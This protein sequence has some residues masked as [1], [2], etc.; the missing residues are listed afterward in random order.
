MVKVESKSLDGLRG[1]AALHVALGH[2]LLYSVGTDLMGECAIVIFFLISGFVMVVG[3]GQKKYS[4]SGGVY[5]EIVCVNLDRLNICGKK[6][7]AG[8]IHSEQDTEKAEALTQGVSFPGYSFLVKRFARLG[9]TYY[10]A[11]LLGIPL[12]FM[13]HTKTDTLILNNVL[14]FLLLTSW[15][16]LYPINYPLWT[17]STMSFFYICYPC[18]IV[19]LQKIDTI[20]DLRNLALRMYYI[21]FAVAV[22]FML[23]FL[24][25]LDSTAW[26]TLWRMFP[27]NRLPV[28]IMGMCIGLMRVL[29]GADHAE[30]PTLIFRKHDAAS[31]AAIY[32]LIILLGIILST[33]VSQ[34]VTIIARGC[35]EVAVPVIFFDWLLELTRAKK[36]KLFSHGGNANMGKISMGFYMLHALVLYYVGLTCYHSR[37]SNESMVLDS[38]QDAFIPLWA[39]PIVIVLALAVGAAFTQFVELPLHD[40]IIAHCLSKGVPKVVENDSDSDQK[41]GKDSS[42][43]T[44][45]SSNSSSDR[46]AV[47]KAK[48]H[49]SNNLNKP[50]LDDVFPI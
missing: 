50:L 16:G 31:P 40:L 36:E 29:P 49:S 20:A 24:V 8:P 22:L 48:L 30:L 18:L 41:S 45:D 15:I 37:N 9:P 39:M 21:Q 27:I 17:I 1:F 42:S 10:I 32:W 4:D 19:R 13:I 23:F 28:F 3:Y 11:T 38:E 35:I 14:S 43:H 2:I 25:V 44:S 12:W 47:K 33:W 6:A 5:G 46:Q 7:T 34:A 26:Y